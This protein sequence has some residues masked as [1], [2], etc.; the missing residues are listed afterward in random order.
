MAGSSDGSVITVSQL[1]LE[2][3]EQHM[4]EKGA[5]L[6]SCIVAAGSFVLRSNSK[7]T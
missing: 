2:S 5:V 7:V 3:A 6:I 4:A 1:L